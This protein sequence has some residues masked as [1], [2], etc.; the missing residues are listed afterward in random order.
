MKPNIWPCPT[1]AGVD[2]EDLALVVE[3]DLEYV[4]DGHQADTLAWKVHAYYKG[5]GVASAAI[6]AGPEDGARIKEPD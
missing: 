5:R 4:T 3:D 2:L 1:L 6:G